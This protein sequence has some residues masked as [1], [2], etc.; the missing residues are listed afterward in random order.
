MVDSVTLLDYSGKFEFE[1]IETLVNQ[2]KSCVEGIE[3]KLPVRKKIVNICVECLENIYKYSILGQADTI[4]LDKFN[5]VVKL[6]SDS[7]ILFLETGNTIHNAKIENLKNRISEMNK[8]SREQLKEKY[9]EIIN[10]T[11]IN[12]KGGAGLGLLDIAL[13]SGNPL[14]YEFKAVDDNLSFFKIKI[15]INLK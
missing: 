9:D 13:K 3:C 2:V 4:F 7:S 15:Q 14:E 8:L 5:A 1:T 11:Q 6:Q 12:E 10:N